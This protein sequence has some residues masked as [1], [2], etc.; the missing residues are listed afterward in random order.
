M[1]VRQIPKAMIN[2]ANY[3]VGLGAARLGWKGER[4]RH[5]SPGCVQCG[6][7]HL[8]CA[9]DAKQ[10][11]NLSFIPA[12]LQAGAVMHAETRVEHLVR[13]RDGWVVHTDKGELLAERVVMC[14]GIV[15][16]PTILL[17]SGIEAGQGL[18]VHLQAVAWGDFEDPVDGHAGI[19]MA[20][21][22][23]EF[24]DVYGHTG[25]GFL[26]EGVGVQGMSFSVQPQAT[27]VTHEEILRRY[28][29]L[30][31]ALSL[32][33]SKA[34]GSVTL[35]PGGRPALAYPLVEADAARQVLFYQRATE[36]FL[37]AGASRVL[38]AHRSQGWLDAPPAEIPMDPGLAYLYSAHPFGGANRGTV[39]DGEGRVKAQTDLWVLDASAF[40]EALGANPQITIAALALE[41]ADRIIAEA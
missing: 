32:V 8:G 29:H 12:A 6:F 35:G 31:G 33:R 11:T 39:T 41:G 23:L 4:L 22:V 15:Q 2:R 10:S 21:G 7:R 34:R 24:A 19:P 1:Q 30:G 27:G 9:Y 17:R 20:Y 26:I 28:R 13:D 3:L 40:P 5:N 16:T 14:A 38:L 18:Q 25:P 37:A 36:M